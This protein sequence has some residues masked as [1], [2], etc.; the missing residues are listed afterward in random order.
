MIVGIGTDMV[1]IDRVACVQARQPRFAL[2]I[3]GE[4]EQ[5]AWRARGCC[6]AFLA[7]RWA[8]KEAVLKALGTG[9]R[10]GLRLRDIQ[11]LNDAL[12]APQV[13]LSGQSAE[14]ARR[15][16]IV[17][18]HVSLSDTDTLALA[19]VVAEGA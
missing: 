2:R 11:V 16:G 7:K 1:E 3:L 13:A 15:L 18:W 17:R 4:T 19:F 12:G 14:R 9:L 5:A 8:A 6:D 10:D